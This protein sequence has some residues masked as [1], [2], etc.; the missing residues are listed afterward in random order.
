MNKTQIVETNA[1]T[2]NL[3]RQGNIPHHRATPY[4]IHGHDIGYVAGKL[5]RELYNY[6]YWYFYPPAPPQPVNFKK[7]HQESVLNFSISLQNWKN[8]STEQLCQHFH[9]AFNK[10]PPVIKINKARVHKDFYKVLREKLH[11]NLPTLHALIKMT[12]ELQPYYAA[13]QEKAHHKKWL[14]LNSV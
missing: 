6:V 2:G 9:N 4:S 14:D 10:L 12:P 13:E 11:R 3:T 7:L 5:I 8:L 1:S